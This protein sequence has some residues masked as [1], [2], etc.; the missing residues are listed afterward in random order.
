M[1]YQPVS[2]KEYNERL[3]L[4]AGEY[5]FEVLNAT[6]G[7]SKSSGAD[8]ITLELL[9]HST[10]SGSR[11]VKAY[12]VASDGGKYQVR[13]FCVSTGLLA[14]Y[15]AGTFCAEDC[16]SKGGWLRLRIEKGKPKDDGSGDWPDKNSVAAFIAG[17]SKAAPASESAPSP[18]P[19]SALVQDKIDD[20]QVPF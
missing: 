20:D 1:K 15:N 12:L 4:P 19:Q 5:A 14:R 10:D 16:L 8:M 3:L 13:A 2:E 18:A 7:Q 11:K 6:P 9:V 17:P